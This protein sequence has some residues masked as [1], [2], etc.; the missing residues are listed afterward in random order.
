[1]PHAP[2]HASP[3]RRR[4]ALHHAHM[5][6]LRGAHCFEDP[7]P[8]LTAGAEAEVQAASTYRNVRMA[9]AF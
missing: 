2:R 1:M 8:V 5:R 4:T 7:L 9:Q 3:A 6:V